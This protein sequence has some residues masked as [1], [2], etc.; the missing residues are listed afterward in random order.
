M[1][2][3]TLSK[4][5]SNPS[6]RWSVLVLLALV[7]VAVLAPWIAP[8]PSQA[9]NSSYVNLGAG[10]IGTVTLA[11][12]QDASVHFW[13]GTDGYGRDILSRVLFGT[14]IS[15]V[16]ALA[17]ATVAVITGSFLGMLA[18]YFR[19]ADAVLMRV[20]DGLMAIPSILLAIALVA[21]LGAE[22]WVVIIAI[23]TPEIPRV[24]RLVRSLVLSLREE[25]FVEAARA[26]ATPTPAILFRHI[27]PNALAPL[28]VQGTFIAAAAI[29]TES[30][31]SFLGLGLSPEIATWGNVMAE[32]RINFS[33][34]PGSVL[35]PALLL[36]PAVLAINMLGD[37]MR[38]VLDPK[39]ARRGAK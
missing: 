28:L 9:M 12:G 3:E 25:P 31:L 36:V 17:C 4:L 33:Q 15:L 37:G 24:T 10:A 19:A 20:V 1:Q 32:G 7:V 35:F 16:V 38:D 14:R 30:A 39:F 13:M 11:N 6:V 21:A 29:L 22:L 2:N 26:L 34:H 5:S 18:G 8:V 23:A 27:L